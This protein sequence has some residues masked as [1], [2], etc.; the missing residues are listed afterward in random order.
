MP[1][2]K[3]AIKKLKQ[4][5]AATERNRA[6]RAGLRTSLKKAGENIEQETLNEIF[7]ALDKA[8]K[9]GLIKKGK[10]DRTKSRLS[11]RLIAIKPVKTVP[12]KT[13]KKK[14]TRK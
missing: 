1:L 5:R 4:D 13:S 8:V 14:I 6:A 3:G 12:T 2:I 9:R 11:H 10:A 7:S